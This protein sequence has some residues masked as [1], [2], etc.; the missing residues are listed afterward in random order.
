M[1]YEEV[2]AMALEIPEVVEALQYGDPA[3]KRRKRFMAA[4]KRDGT[5]A[6]KLDFETRDRLLGEVP[7]ICLITPH[8]HG[9]P[10]FLVRIEQAS[11][12]LVQEILH[13]SWEDAPKPA[14]T[15][16]FPP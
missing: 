8:F 4:A 2:L 10:G 15:R 6:V 14:R 1:T 3:I 11:P 9:W 5:L 16:P 12:E 7:E 13:A